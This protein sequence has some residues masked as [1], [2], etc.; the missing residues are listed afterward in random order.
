ML[1][2]TKQWK[3]AF[4]CWDKAT[5]SK[6]QFKLR[7]ERYPR[8]C[9]LAD[10]IQTAFSGTTS[11]TLSSSQSS[12]ETRLSL[13]TYPI[14][15]FNYRFLGPNLHW[16]GTYFEI[17]AAAHLSCQGR[18]RFTK[19]HLTSPH[20][21]RILPEGPSAQ[22]LSDPRWE[23]WSQAI[24]V[25]WISIAGSLDWKW[26]CWEWQWGVG[27][28]NVIPEACLLEHCRP[29]RISADSIAW[30]CSTKELSHRV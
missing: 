7:I 21:Y 9:S 6:A 29:G 3:I 25:L 23:Y 26:G 1:N 28:R 19:A 4:Q 24:G 22:G 10:R 27:C 8:G 5:E 15:W 16:Q 20:N 11:L 18:C 17:E 13:S 30:T 12:I 2:Q 14:K